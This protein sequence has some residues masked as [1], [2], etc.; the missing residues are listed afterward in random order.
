[1]PELDGAER[2]HLRGLAHPLKPVVI[3][4]EG[5]LSEAVL[6]ALDE[7]LERHELVKV[8][9]RQPQDKKRSARELA[10]AS[11]AALC[12]LVGHTVVLY[13]PHPEKP[14]IELPRRD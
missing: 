10:E 2:R 8:R 13:R 4:G 11:G 14:K 5:G 3:V 7:A 6:R 9:L 12:G 1:M